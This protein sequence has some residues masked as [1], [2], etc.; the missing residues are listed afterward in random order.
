MGE[1]QIYSGIEAVIRFLDIE[2]PT[3][4][5]YE[6]Q[7]YHKLMNRKKYYQFSDTYPENWIKRDL[8]SCYKAAKISA[9]VYYGK[10][11]ISLGKVKSGY[12]DTQIPFYYPSKRTEQHIHILDMVEYSNRF[13]FSSKEYDRFFLYKCDKVFSYVSWHWKSCMQNPIHAGHYS[14][15]IREVTKGE[16]L[17]NIIKAYKTVDRY[18]ASKIGLYRRIRVFIV[19]MKKMEDIIMHA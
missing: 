18:Y 11:S 7:A 16:M 19:A 5:I 14:H 10:T 6:R 3:G 17:G 2:H 4:L 15:E 1:L 12:E 9:N 8:L 13:K